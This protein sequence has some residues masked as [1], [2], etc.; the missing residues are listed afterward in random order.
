MQTLGK[1]S[2]R[3][4]TPLG[5]SLHH[6]CLQNSALKFRSSQ[7]CQHP[8]YL[9]K[10]HHGQNRAPSPPFNTFNLLSSATPSPLISLYQLQDALFV[11]LFTYDTFFE[12]LSANCARRHVLEK[13]TWYCEK[14][15]MA[16][17]GSW[18]AGHSR[19]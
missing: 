15:K 19:I 9:A 17:S 14:R 2:N 1:D 10:S 3:G 13:G 7:V 18:A 6:Y 11:S 12:N 16:F 5:S 4:S 8:G